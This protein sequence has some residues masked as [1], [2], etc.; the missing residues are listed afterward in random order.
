MRD[1]WLT[2]RYNVVDMLIIMVC[3]SLV[4]NALSWIFG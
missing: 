1:F 2:K 4:G 3:G